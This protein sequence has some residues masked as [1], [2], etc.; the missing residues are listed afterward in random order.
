MD[1][2]LKNSGDGY[3]E[4]TPLTTTGEHQSYNR[5]E[6]NSGNDNGFGTGFAPEKGGQHLY[7]SLVI[8]KI[9]NLAMPCWTFKKLCTGKWYF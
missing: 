7:H 2:E 1:H 6:L 3:R 5:K 9:E 4:Q 8:L